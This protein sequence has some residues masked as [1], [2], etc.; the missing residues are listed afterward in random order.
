MTMSRLKLI[1]LISI[2]I[3]MVGCSFRRAP[4]P[5][6]KPV[7]KKKVS[8]P[9]SVKSTPPKSN[10]PNQKLWNQESHVK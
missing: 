9:D 5:E 3:G 4:E 7:V 10:Q 2:C 8:P 6:L 1:L